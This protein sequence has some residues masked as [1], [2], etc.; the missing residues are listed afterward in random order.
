M[1][2][3]A[4][5]SQAGRRLI[6]VDVKVLIGALV[7][8][9]ALGACQTDDVARP[10]EGSSPSE[11][12][13]TSSGVRGVSYRVDPYKVNPS[14]IRPRAT[15]TNTG[16]VV[17]EYGN[18][19]TVEIKKDERWVVV[20]QP[21]DSRTFC[22]FTSEAYLMNPGE[23]TSQRISVC[24]RDG[25]PRSLQPG[26]YRLTKTLRESGSGRAFTAETFFTVA[27]SENAGRG[28]SFR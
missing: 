20:E 12:R 14:G 5:H 26:L 2:S 25:E 3:R 13:T 10:D 15:L 16:E 27:R 17:L 22:A 24:D 28:Q 7:C 8:A 19:Y 6:V 11:T 21:P 1:V 23:S 18:A 4:E 9:A